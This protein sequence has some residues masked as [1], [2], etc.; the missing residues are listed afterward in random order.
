[1][2]LKYKKLLLAG[3]GVLVCSAAWLWMLRL[4]DDDGLGQFPHAFLPHGEVTY[5]AEAVIIRLAPLESPPTPEGLDPAWTC[6]DHAFD[7]ANG[8]PWIF[9]MSP[10]RSAPVGPVHPRLKHSPPADQM[11]PFWTPE[12]ERQLAAYHRRFGG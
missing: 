7:D 1:M 10:T 6:S 3:G 9:A 2:E 4:A 12:A 5:D 8:R 11:H